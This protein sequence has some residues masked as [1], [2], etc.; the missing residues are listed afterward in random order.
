MS[1]SNRSF[2]TETPKTG[3]Q[4]RTPASRCRNWLSEVVVGIGS[5]TLKIPSYPFLLVR[6]PILGS[7]D[8]ILNS[9]H[10][11][12]IS[13]SKLILSLQHPVKF[14][15]FSRWPFSVFCSLDKIQNSLLKTSPLED[16]SQITSPLEVLNHWSSP[17]L[18]YSSSCTLYTSF[19]RFHWSSVLDSSSGTLYTSFRRFRRNS[20]TE[21]LGL[22][23]DNFL[24]STVDTPQQ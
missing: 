8:V 18:L 15:R 6:S 7:S 2:G 14:R 23:T 13:T 5:F 1:H 3:S 21:V 4:R 22:P 19:R 24:D 12:T 20:V 10:C 11:L 17:A 9:R 16:S